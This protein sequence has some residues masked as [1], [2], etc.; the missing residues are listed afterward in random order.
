MRPVRLKLKLYHLILIHHHRHHLTL[1]NNAWTIKYIPLST[2]IT[3][4]KKKKNLL[5]A[6]VGLCIG[7]FLSCNN[8]K[9]KAEGESTVTSSTTPPAKTM[10]TATGNT[11]YTLKLEAADLAT[12][13]AN[14]DTK[15]LI[16]QFTSYNSS[17]TA[18][19]LVAYGA[20]K[21]DVITSVP[22]TLT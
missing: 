3:I 22:I 14:K 13:L 8:N 9:P 11:F 5:L 1:I 12:L 15:K 16:V 4:M 2:K 7:L 18:L 21:N 20:K 17:D 6:I 19:R 10:F